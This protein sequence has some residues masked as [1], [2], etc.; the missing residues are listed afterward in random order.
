MTSIGPTIGPIN[1]LT[2]GKYQLR[3]E[4]HHDTTDVPGNIT[5]EFYATSNAER[6][7]LTVILAGDGTTKSSYTWL[8]GTDGEG[9]TFV[10]F[11]YQLTKDPIIYAVMCNDV[12]RLIV[13]SNSGDP[14]IQITKLEL[15]TFNAFQASATGNTA[16]ITSSCM[17]TTPCCSLY[18]EVV[19]PPNYKPLIIFLSIGIAVSAALGVG[20]GFGLCK[21]MSL[22][23]K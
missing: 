14:I 5:L 22:K 18:N 11:E 7:K 19:I 15:V 6:P 13:G 17:I 8:D 21:L 16:L 2:A 9:D 10:E 3:V 23:K 12:L 20:A 1:N 4:T